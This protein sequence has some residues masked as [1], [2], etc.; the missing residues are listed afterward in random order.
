DAGASL[1]GWVRAAVP[2]AVCLYGRDLTQAGGPGVHGDDPVGA[3]AR[4]L[5]KLPGGAGVF[6]V[7]AVS[8]EHTDP[9]RGGGVGDG[10]LV[11]AA[12]VWV[13]AA[14]VARAGRA[15]SRHAGDDHAA[16]T[17]DAAAG[18]PDVPPSGMDGNVPAAHRA[19]LLRER[20]QHLSAA[21]V[22]SDDPA[23]PL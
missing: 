2:G 12:G 16:V 21:A 14:A 4:G 15:V 22:L 18:I 3:E 9:V 7:L 23:G 19:E 11:G 8:A 6:P 13:C 17:G 1:P 20:V 5:E 10:S